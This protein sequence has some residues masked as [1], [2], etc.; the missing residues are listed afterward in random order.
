R[1]RA[2][3]YPLLLILGSYLCFFP[4][5]KDVRYTMPMLVGVAIVGVHWISRIRTQ[6]LRLS[7][8][9]LVGAY[10]V[11]AFQ[12]VSFGFQAL[13][14]E[15]R[16]GPL[17]VFAQGGYSTA[18][19]PTT[20]Q[21]HQEEIIREIANYPENQ[22][23]TGVLNDPDTMWFNNSGLN[24]YALREGVPI[25]PPEQK[26]NFLIERTTHGGP[27]RPGYGLLR[28]FELPDHSILRLFK[29]KREG[30]S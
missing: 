24:Y 23:S 1:S 9:L 27:N 13:P 30:A 17:K 10:F 29:K 7:L 5:H 20:E 21:W 28:R 2:N 4:I 25:V 11:F 8:A 3:T 26:P 14:K 15:I 6:A 16:V 18:S 19:P 22:R 12:G